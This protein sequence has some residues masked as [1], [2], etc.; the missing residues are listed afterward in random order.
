MQS[1]SL[2]EVIIE[3]QHLSRFGGFS[4]DEA[5]ALVEKYHGSFAICLQW[6]VLNLND[7]MDRAKQVLK[8]LPLHLLSAIRVQDVGAARV[9]QQYDFNVPIHLIVE[10]GSRNLE[11]LLGWEEYF[12]SQLQ[13][14]L[15]SNETPKALLKY[16]KEALKTP[17]EIQGLGR[18]CLF[19][20]PRRLL[21][22]FFKDSQ[23]DIIQAW[24][25]YDDLPHHSFPTLETT[26]GSFLFHYYDLFLL[27]LIPGLGSLVHT[28]RLDLRFHDQ[29]EIIQSLDKWTHPF[30]LQQLLTVK[31]SWHVKTTHGF[32]RA[33]KTDMS[34]KRLK[35]KHLSIENKHLVGT[36]LEM[37]RDEY[38]AVSTKETIHVGQTLLLKNP[39]GKEMKVRLTWIQ[40]TE[41]KPVEKKAQAGIW[42]IPYVRGAISKTNLY[43]CEEGQRR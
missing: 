29:F 12:G 21:H 10:I 35:N 8:Q 31:K 40:D 38:L 11:S 23:Q 39:E 26:H 33:N 28:M 43:L 1:T 14:F 18:I 4:S 42:L 32:Y 5:C 37:A 2:Q 15:L 25:N 13:R 17:L 41:C 9:I 7:E 6:D 22:R 30:D 3:H 27:D 36:V 20:T 34:I 19:Y 24:V 16:Y